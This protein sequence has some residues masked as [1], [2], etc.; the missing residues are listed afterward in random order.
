MTNFSYLSSGEEWFELE[1]FSAVLVDVSAAKLSDV[2]LN[3]LAAFRP[4]IVAFFG[5]SSEAWHDAYDQL[6]IREDIEC[7][8]I[9]Y[10]NEPIDE[11]VWEFFNVHVPHSSESREAFVIGVGSDWLLRAAEKSQAEE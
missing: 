10:S 6:M 11:V 8:T 4:G 1:S 5:R 7:L 9:W 3:R 2:L